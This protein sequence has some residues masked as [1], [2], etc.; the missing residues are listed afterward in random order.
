[1][2]WMFWILVVLSCS[3]CGMLGLVAGINLNPLSTVRFVP[4]MGSLADWV[5]G[6]GSVSAALVALYLANQQRKNNT[7]RIEISQS[8]TNHDFDLSFVSTGERPPIVTGVFIRSPRYKK[9][10]LLGLKHSSL[11]EG[12]LGSYEYGEVKRLHLDRY[13]DVAM[14]LKDEVGN[15]DF[16]GL[17]LIVKTGIA[18]FKAQLDQ[19]IVCRL[20]KSIQRV[21]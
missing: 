18:E 5:S 10:I 1:M 8:H 16:S 9:Q 11:Y 15:D 20:H 19:N 12:V 7:A 17:Q 3:A 21:K 4:E 2:K 6:L 13:L 14:S